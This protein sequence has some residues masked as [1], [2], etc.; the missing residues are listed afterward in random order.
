MPCSS[1]T[2]GGGGDQ[3]DDASKEGGDRKG[4][5]GLT[6]GYSDE[7]SKIIEAYL[8]EDEVDDGDFVVEINLFKYC[9]E[10]P[11]VWEQH[12]TSIEK[13]ARRKVCSVPGYTIAFT[14]LKLFPLC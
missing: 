2:R 1:A 5:H 6:N 8:V 10:D 12:E 4:S 13:W 7:E 14:S 3:P 9:R 11:C